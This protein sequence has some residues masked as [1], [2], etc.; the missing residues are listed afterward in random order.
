MAETNEYE[1][2]HQP[3]GSAVPVEEGMDPFE[4][5]VQ[6]REVLRKGRPARSKRVHV[7]DPAVDFRG[8]EDPRDR[9]HIP[10]GNG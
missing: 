7:C 2:E 5:R 9:L 4:A 3:S 1:V 6:L 8:N 10:P